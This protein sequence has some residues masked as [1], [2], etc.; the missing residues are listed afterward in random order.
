[1]NEVDTI[2]II[3]KKFLKKLSVST[4]CLISSA[5]LLPVNLCLVFCKTDSKICLRKPEN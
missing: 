3:F 4:N 1:M 5:Y 2:N